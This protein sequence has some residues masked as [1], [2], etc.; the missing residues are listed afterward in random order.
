MSLPNHEHESMLDTFIN[1]L[2]RLVGKGG[3]TNTPPPSWTSKRASPS[4][5]AAWAT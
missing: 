1:E 3:A 5:A 4:S 2:Q